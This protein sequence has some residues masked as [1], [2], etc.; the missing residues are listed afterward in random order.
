MSLRVDPKWVNR[1]EQQVRTQHTRTIK[2]KGKE[3]ARKVEVVDDY[4]ISLLYG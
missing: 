3:S 2:V 1:S 4:S